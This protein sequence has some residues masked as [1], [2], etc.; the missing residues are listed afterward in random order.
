MLGKLPCI[1]LRDTLANSM[2]MRRSRPR[3]GGMIRIPKTT[4]G[5]LVRVVPAMRANSLRNRLVR[6]N[7]PTLSV[8]IHSGVTQILGRISRI[9]L[10]DLYD[11]SSRDI[12]VRFRPPNNLV[13][14]CW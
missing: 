1:T 5:H 14:N 8:D 2:Y 11:I 13:L 6:Q 12:N 9:K 4:R 7:G 3:P 10:D